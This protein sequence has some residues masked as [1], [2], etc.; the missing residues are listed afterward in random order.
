MEQQT[1]H[2]KLRAPAK[3]NL[4]LKILGKR[5]DGYHE[6]ETL[7]QKISLYDDLKLR[8]T[9]EPG[10]RIQCPNAD[11]PDDTDNIAVRA[12]QLFLKETGKEDQGIHIVLK[13]NI[14]IAAGLGGG[15][16]DAAAVLNGLD[17]LLST[18]CSTEQLAE[19]GG[20]IGS[21]VPLF[22]YN[23]SAA[24]ATGRG[25]HLVQAPPLADYRIL[26]VNPGIP[27]STK[28]AYAT[29][30]APERKNT[31][32]EEQKTS[33]FF[34]SEKCRQQAVSGGGQK[35][36]VPEDL[37]NDLERV[38]IQRHPAL[39]DLKNQLLANGATGAM[40][41]GSGSTVF[42]LFHQDD[43]KKAEQCYSLLQQKY[44]QVYLASP[45]SE[46]RKKR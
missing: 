20:R 12:A 6:L 25:E 43:V 10:I 45:L 15:S 24:H 41:S 37:H 17:Q 26:L 9:A 40:M 16:S 27:V 19:L 33:I 11:L 22:I 36:R 32:T 4:S 28:W 14:P 31:L 44:D 42:G 39:Q 35:F 3:I 8:L 21:D 46:D 7:M 5:K 1:T 30:S 13:K 2:I 23:F 38:T 18:T 29:F 34:C